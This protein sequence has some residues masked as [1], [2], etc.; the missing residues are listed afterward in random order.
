[1]GFITVGLKVHS[2]GIIHRD[3]K[4][5]NIF[6][7]K[8]GTIKIADLGVGTK[9]P[10]DDDT[11]YGTEGTYHFMSPECLFKSDGIITRL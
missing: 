7:D 2:N 6:L 4:P 10:L 11:I 3:I 9:V 1:M 5:D 8:N